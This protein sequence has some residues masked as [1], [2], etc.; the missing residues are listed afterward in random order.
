M[1]DNRKLAEEVYAKIYQAEA[2]DAP[3]EMILEPIAAYGEARYK[4]GVEAAAVENAQLVE[5]CQNWEYRY[6][7]V[8]AMKVV[9]EQ[10]IEEMEAHYAN[11]D[12]KVK[13][14]G[15]LARDYAG[16]VLELEAKLKEYEQFNASLKQVYEESPTSNTVQEDK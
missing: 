14:N 13:E 4:A 11:L 8:W 9:A 6:D 2:D 5:D 1:D 15:Q 10:R 3:I 7:S 12:F 16:Q